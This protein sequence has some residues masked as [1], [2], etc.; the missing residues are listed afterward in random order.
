MEARQELDWTPELH[1][2]EFDFDTA[3][4]EL[5]GWELPCNFA[6][7][8]AEEIEQDLALGHPAWGSLLRTAE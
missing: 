1:V 5:V 2:L 8:S 4:E 3:P 7:P 6:M